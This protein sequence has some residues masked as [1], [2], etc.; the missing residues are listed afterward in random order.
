MEGGWRNKIALPSMHAL[1]IPVMNTW[2]SSATLWSYHYNYKVGALSQGV[3]LGRF[4]Q[5]PSMIRCCGPC[6]GFLDLA[7]P[8]RSGVLQVYSNTGS[9]ISNH[10]IMS[11]FSGTACT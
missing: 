10:V 11:G 4:C 5:G 3:A 7:H 9:C 6:T 1:G 2:N 8:G